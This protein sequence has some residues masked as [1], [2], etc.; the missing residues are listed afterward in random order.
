M[1]DTVISIRVAKADRDAFQAAA[2]AEGRSLSNWA[3]WVLRSASVILGPPERVHG[4]GLAT[5]TSGPSRG[6]GTGF[7][8]ASVGSTPTGPAIPQKTHPPPEPTNCP[9]R[10]PVGTYDRACG[11][12]H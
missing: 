4:A 9:N 6:A 8:P 12:R 7:D 3:Y 2:E 10:L 5:L 11:R 1:N